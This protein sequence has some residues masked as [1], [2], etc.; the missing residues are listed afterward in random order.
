MFRWILV[1]LSVA[2]TFAVSADNKCG[3]NCTRKIVQEEIA[4]VNAIRA[5][6]K[7]N[8]KKSRHQYK[9]YPTQ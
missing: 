3:V 4:K 1:L 2:W 6:I 7:S 9:K 5:G 8:P